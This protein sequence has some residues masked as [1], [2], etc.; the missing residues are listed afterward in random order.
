M[1]S[2][3]P[4]NM[5]VPQTGNNHSPPR[6]QK[7]VLRSAVR[8]NKLMFTFCLLA[9]ISIGINV[10]LVLDVSS[11]LSRGSY[12]SGS[13]SLAANGDPAPGP[14]TLSDVRNGIL[15]LLGIT[16]ISFGSII[17][18]YKRRVVEPLNELS[19]TVR[20]ISR[21][22]LS[23]TAPSGHNQIGEIG[24]VINELAANFQE[25]LLLTG[26]TAGNSRCSLELM[27][28]ALQMD[29]NSP[30]FH[31]V[32]EQVDAIKKDLD[33]LGSVVQDFEFYH[34]H[35]DGQKVVPFGSESKT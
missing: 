14:G 11:E 9:C 12:V 26:T 1:N 15:F 17:L 30:D 10:K 13:L 4:Q 33:L 6:E 8:R 24:G 32:K 23:V 28:Q 31:R 35:F 18:L 3:L 29:K 19:D 7:T 21:G 2:E 16:I 22:N 34:T 27:E 20:E 5:V 25:V